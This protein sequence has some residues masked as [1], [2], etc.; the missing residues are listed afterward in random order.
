MRKALLASRYNGLLASSMFYKYI[1]LTYELISDPL[2]QCRI[3]DSIDSLQLVSLLKFQIPSDISIRAGNKFY[4]NSVGVNSVGGGHRN[5]RTSK[6]SLYF[7]D[8]TR[9]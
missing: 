5:G 8:A 4:Y 2:A 1:S 6:R 9:S 7:V 3:R